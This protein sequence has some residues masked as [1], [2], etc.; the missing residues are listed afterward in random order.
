MFYFCEMKMKCMQV[1]LN[2]LTNDVNTKDN[3][4]FYFIFHLISHEI[5]FVKRK[6]LLIFI[7]IDKYFQTLFA[8]FM[9]Q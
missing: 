2:S 9:L 3:S 1:E 6:T 7:D 4:V 8:I 5:S